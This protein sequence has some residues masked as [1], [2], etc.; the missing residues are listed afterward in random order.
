MS[1][2]FSKPATPAMPTPAPPPTMPDPLSPAVRE[3]QKRALD[4]TTKG[5]RSSTVLT[6]AASRAATTIA[7]SQSLGG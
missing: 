3:A 4:N 5:G 2:L 1:N 7:G 6:T